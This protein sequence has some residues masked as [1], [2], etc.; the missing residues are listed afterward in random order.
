MASSSK[1]HRS[2]NRSH[3]RHHRSRDSQP[4]AVRPNTQN[5]QN[6]GD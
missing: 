6:Y 3:N 4:S 2:H 5:L 1:R